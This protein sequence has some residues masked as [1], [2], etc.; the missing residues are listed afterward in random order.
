M[1]GSKLRLL[2]GRLLAGESISSSAL[3]QLREESE[4]VYPG[5]GAGIGRRLELLKGS[6]A[7]LDAA[8]IGASCLLSLWH[9]CLPLAL[10]IALRSRRGALHCQGILGPQGSGKSTLALALE[11]LLADL[12]LRAVRLSLDDLYLRRAE[13]LSLG[14][15]QLHHRGPPGTHDI[16]LGLRTF[17]ELGRGETPCWLPRFDKSAWQG[18]GDRWAW[19]DL[20][21]GIELT[22]RVEGGAVALVSCRFQ[23][24][25]VELPDRMG[26]P[27]P[28]QPLTPGFV[29][30]E[31]EPVTVYRNDDGQIRL[32]GAEQ[33]QEVLP[34]DLPVGWQLVH[35]PIDVVVFEGWFL[36][37]RPV[38]LDAWPDPFTRQ[39]NEHLHAYLPLW[40]PIDHLLVL[41][42][43]QSHASREWRQAA[44]QQ[45]IA[46]GRP[47]M[48]AEQI[49]LFIEYF[50]RALP[51]EL[52]LDPQVSDGRVGDLVATLSADHTPFE[53]YRS[54][55][56]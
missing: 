53:I 7:R 38:Q 16:Q 39:S 23:G 15:P 22:G 49:A 17:A 36:G 27:V 5:Q 37:M 11:M 26:T 13:R 34:A 12:G 32:A 51:P 47:G 10:D 56:P 52:F 44:E 55:H 4:V 18:E 1:A 40:K 3:A 6:Y 35:S 2:L 31:G 43:L 45:R 8:G 21:P 54:P 9:L 28:L 33:D 46:A 50:R 42:P 48:N 19:P 41:K 29:L 30:P 24:K 14:D 25:S 20:H